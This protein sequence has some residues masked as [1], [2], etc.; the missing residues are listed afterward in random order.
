MGDAHIEAAGL[1]GDDVFSTKCLLDPLK[2][3]CKP[4]SNKIVVA[5][6]YK[7]L[8]QWVFGLLEYI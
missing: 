5:T 3:H 7:Q 1:T 8:V 6:A 2:D 4:G